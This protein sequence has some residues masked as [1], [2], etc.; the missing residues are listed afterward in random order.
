M[1]ALDVEEDIAWHDTALPAL[2]AAF[3]AHGWERDGVILA[4]HLDTGAL[5]HPISLDCEDDGWYRAEIHTGGDEDVE[6]MAPRDPVAAVRTAL[7]RA[8]LAARQPGMESR[9]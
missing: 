3:P 7:R 9:P 1:D 6:G 5:V 4:G 2:R 8:G